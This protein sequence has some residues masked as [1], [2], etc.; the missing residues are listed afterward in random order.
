MSWHTERMYA[1]DVETTGVDVKSDRIVSASVVM[2]GGPDMTLRRTWLINPG[3]KIPASASDIHGISNQ[4]AAQGKDAKT[5]IAEIIEL[6]NQR[7][8]VLVVFNAR[9]DLSILIAEAAR[10]GLALPRVDTIVD[11]LVLDKWLDRFR[12][13]SRTLSALCKHYGIP[14]TNAHDASAD[15]LAAA[16]LAWVIASR[17]QPQRRVQSQADRENLTR[18]YDCWQIARHD[19]QALHHLQIRAA[20]LQAQGLREHFRKQ[21]NAAWQSVSSGWP[22]CSSAAV[23]V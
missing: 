4:M 21:G 5:A 9:F 12:P 19:K 2:C 22:S 14:L 20:A 16:R 10:Y 23:C 1:F 17:V 11:P 18:L 15:A 6:L 7:E 13:G 3:V 8:G